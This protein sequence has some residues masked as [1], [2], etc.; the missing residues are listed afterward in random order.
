MHYGKMTEGTLKVGD[1]VSARIDAGRRKAI[2]RAHTATHLLDKTLRTVLGDHV[3]QA[4]SL[5]EEDYLRFDFTH[6]AALTAEELSR[7]SQ[8]INNAILEGFAVEAKEMPIEEAKKTGAIALFSEKYG[9]VVRVVNVGG[10]YSVEFCGGTHL[11]N[12]A[13]A[14]LFH[15]ESEFSVASGVRR[16][17]AVTGKRALEEMNRFQDMLFQAAAAL[18]VKPIDLKEKAGQMVAETRELRQTIEKLKAKEFVSEADQF[19]MS[20]KQ[21]K[22]L[23][24]FSMS[25]S[26]MSADDMRK[27]GDFLRDK[28]ATVVALMASV[29]EEKITFLAV[30]GKEAVAKGVKAGDIIKTIAP[31]CGGK[32]G[33]KPDSA[34]GGGSDLLK[35]DDALA[36]LD[37]F[38]NEKAKD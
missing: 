19:L 13:K 18:K 12:S 5:V 1:A 15:I 21:V 28:D 20:A 29:N 2:M 26:G 27:M 14:G 30:C 4:G 10:G 23:R 33:G 36:A 31:I 16:I 3:H 9:D 7:V 8:E 37:D 34:M 11:D 38:V 17:E 25:R 24:V 35:L 22:G 6:F 32:G